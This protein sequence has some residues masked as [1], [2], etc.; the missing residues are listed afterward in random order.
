MSESPWSGPWLEHRKAFWWEV[1]HSLLGE[2][3]FHCSSSAGLEEQ[4]QSIVLELCCGKA[5]RKREGRKRVRGW[6]WPCGER[7]EGRKRRMARE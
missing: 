5:E 6:P 4:R 7:V 3:L 2:S 1:R